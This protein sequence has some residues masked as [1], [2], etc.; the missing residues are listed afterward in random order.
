MQIQQAIVRRGG[1]SY[2]CLWRGYMLRVSQWTR[3]QFH[4]IYF[5]VFGVRLLTRGPHLLRYK[6]PFVIYSNITFNG[7]LR[8]ITHWGAYL[9]LMLT[10][11]GLRMLWVSIRVLISQP[12]W[13]DR[14]QISDTLLDSQVY[15]KLVW[16]SRGNQIFWSRLPAN[17]R[18]AL[19]HHQR[20]KK[21]PNSH[22]TA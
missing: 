8:G 7:P 12:W 17:P 4:K 10:H 18:R 14:W 1:C 13:Q 6:T 15:I 5:M 20:S 3:S 22:F 21:T 9:I 2:G 16:P 11:S 19:S